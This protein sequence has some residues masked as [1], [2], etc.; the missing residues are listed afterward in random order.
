MINFIAVT[1]NN[2]SLLCY[3]AFSEACCGLSNP[4]LFENP[5]LLMFNYDNNIFKSCIPDKTEADEQ[6]K[7]SEPQVQ[8]S[9]ANALAHPGISPPNVQYATPQLGAGHA[10]VFSTEQDIVNYWCYNNL[11]N[12]AGHFYF[13]LHSMF[14]NNFQFAC[15]DF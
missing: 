13:A 3:P 8:S 1:I 10:M 6:Q 11:L 14:K 15:H 12:E 5:M 2:G 7:H 9:P 4:L